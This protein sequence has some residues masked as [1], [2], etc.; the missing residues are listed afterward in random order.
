MVAFRIGLT[1]ML[2]VVETA[3]CPAP[4][5]K[6]YAVV[7]VLFNAGAQLPVMPFKEVVGKGFNVVPEHIA[8]IGLNVGTT[9]ALTVI[10]CVVVEAHCPAVGVKV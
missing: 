8:G 5:V 10:V 7:V 2:S 6:V 3:H 4:G 1:A 9:A